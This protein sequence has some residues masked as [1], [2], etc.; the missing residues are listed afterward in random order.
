MT[1]QAQAEQHQTDLAVLIAA[2]LLALRD[3]W[4]SLVTPEDVRDALMTGLPG[5]VALYGSAAAALA[6]DWYDD[7]RDE[8]EIDGR[9]RAIVADL[10]DI[11]RT[12]SLARWGIDPLFGAEP[13]VKATQ[14]LL[15][16]G[17]QRIITDLSRD[18]ITQSALADPQALGWQ[19]IGR[20]EGDCAFCRML[21]AR[22]AVYTEATVD[23]ASHD[24]CDCIA[25][26]AFGGR[27]LPVKPY[28]PSER[29][30]TE[31]DRARVR[32]WLRDNP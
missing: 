31:A 3:L 26:P 30:T 2:A 13:D 25:V 10:P 5:L 16:G 17:L 15:E 7:V 6:A 28:T 12:D 8:L 23:F 1:T 19:R 21:I 18:T 14:T 9:F 24:H 22:G 4:R 20:G 11:G 27:E 32:K 29:G